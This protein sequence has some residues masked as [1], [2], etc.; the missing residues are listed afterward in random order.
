MLIAGHC[1]PGWQQQ[2][3]CGPLGWAGT[4]LCAAQL[5]VLG[6]VLYLSELDI[7]VGADHP[8][9]A[10]GS[11]GRNMRGCAEDLVQHPIHKKD[12]P[13]YSLSLSLCT[14]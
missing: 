9:L 11:R 8:H 5:C 14:L 2:G 4:G 3:L 6:Q 12:P 1:S 10:G 13:K 7:N